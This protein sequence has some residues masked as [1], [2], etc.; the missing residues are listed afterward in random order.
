VQRLQAVLETD[1]ALQDYK[2]VHLCM[3]LA[4][5]DLH[6]RNTCSSY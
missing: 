5:T 1:F 2:V 4:E 3:D 6:R